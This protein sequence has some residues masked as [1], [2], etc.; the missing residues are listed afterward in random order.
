MDTTDFCR[1]SRRPACEFVTFARHSRSSD[2]RAIVKR[3]RPATLATVSIRFDCVL[4]Y[5]PLRF[6]Y[7]ILR[8][9]TCRD[10]KRPA[11]GFIA[12]ARRATARGRSHCRCTTS[13]N[14]RPREADDQVMRDAKLFSAV[15]IHARARRATATIYAIIAISNGICPFETHILY[16]ILCW[17][18]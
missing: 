3:L 16:H 7:D 4:V 15:S 17:F 1:Y 11:V 12:R 14:S 8:R 6:V 10:R 13:F 9:D 5:L 2:N 18:A